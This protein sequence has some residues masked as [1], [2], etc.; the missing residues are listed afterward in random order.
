M[1]KRTTPMSRARPQPAPGP[2][3]APSHAAAT[4]TDERERREAAGDDAALVRY[5]DKWSRRIERL[6]RA[7]PGRWCVPG[8]SDEEVRDALT[9]G[10]IEAVRAPAADASSPAAAAAG[11]SPKEWGLR[12]IERHLAR[13]RKTFRLRTR[14][15]DLRDAP[16]PARGPTEEERWLEREA[17][18]TRALAGRLAELGLNQPQRRWLAAMKEAARGGAFFRASDAPNLSAASRLLGKNRSSAQRAFRELHTRFAR[19]RGKLD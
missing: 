14:T 19:E 12:V 16:L 18:S 9:L 13:L 7:H 11:A 1:P 2:A 3:A 8:W 17:D 5:Q 15:V 4:A 10:L 6:Q